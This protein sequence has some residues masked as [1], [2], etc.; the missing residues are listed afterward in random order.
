MTARIGGSSVAVLGRW[1]SERVRPRGRARI[2]GSSVLDH[3]A[4]AQRSGVSSIAARRARRLRV[5]A[6]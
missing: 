1:W 6:M 5:V 3:L 2:G 4:V